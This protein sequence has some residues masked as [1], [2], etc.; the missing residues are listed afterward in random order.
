MAGGQAVPSRW[1]RKMGTSQTPSLALGMPSKGAA[2][3]SDPGGANP[4]LR[5]LTQL[6]TAGCSLAFLAARQEIELDKGK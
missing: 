2:G 6:H 5:D 4:P 1:E 3:L